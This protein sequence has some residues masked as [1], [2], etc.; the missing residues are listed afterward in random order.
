ME[1]GAGRFDAAEEGREEDSGGGACDEYE[2][3]SQG[4]AG[5]VEVE[6]AGWSRSGGLGSGVAQSAAPDEHDE[7]EGQREGDGGEKGAGGMAVEGVLRVNLF[8][9][10]SDHQDIGDGDV[11]GDADEDQEG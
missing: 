7:T 6:R 3:Q 5:A 11:G 2:C 1:E 4:D 8:G 10:G 9:E